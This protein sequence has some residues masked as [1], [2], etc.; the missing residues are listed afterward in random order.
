MN[1]LF[2]YLPTC[3][4]AEEIAD[5]LRSATIP[6]ADV[7]PN[8]RG[9]VEY[10]RDRDHVWF[11]VERRPAEVANAFRGLLR[12]DPEACVIVLEYSFIDAVKAVAAVLASQPG[13]VIDTDCGDTIDGSGFLARL[14]SDPWWDWRRPT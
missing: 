5:A 2:V 10:G 13:A 8:G 14:E 12:R 11:F 4:T 9:L 6:V 7:L 1:A 3:R